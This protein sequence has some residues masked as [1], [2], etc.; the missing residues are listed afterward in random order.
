MELPNNALLE[1][2]SNTVFNYRGV[3][4]TTRCGGLIAAWRS[5]TTCMAQHRCSTVNICAQV[6][7]VIWRAGGVTGHKSQ[8]AALRPDTPVVPEVLQ[9]PTLASP[10]SDTDRSSPGPTQRAQWT[11]RHSLNNEAF[12]VSLALYYDS[13][14]HSL[15]HS[16]SN[17]LRYSQ[18]HSLT[19]SMLRSLPTSA[20][21]TPLAAL[22][23]L[24]ARGRCETL[25][26]EPSH[27]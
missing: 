14:S 3:Y 22:L 17:S 20:R 15:H 24:G 4:N 26:Q 10:V 16:L 19:R 1:L 12:V 8:S 5:H 7:T 21:T 11:E 9:W 25:R 18:Q 6:N 27:E 2:P 23:S 13:L